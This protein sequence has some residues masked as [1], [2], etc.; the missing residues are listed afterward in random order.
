MA[1]PLDRR[2]AFVRFILGSAQMF[3]AAPAIVL[4]LQTGISDTSLIAAVLACVLSTASVVLF[5]RWRN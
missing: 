3:T 5:G 2:P 1:T 4:L